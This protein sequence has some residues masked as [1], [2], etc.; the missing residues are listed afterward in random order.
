MEYAPGTDFEVGTDMILLSDLSQL[1]A[2][3]ALPVSR[4]HEEIKPNSGRPSENSV[5]VKYWIRGGFVPLGA[6]RQDGSSHPHAGTGFGF[7]WAISWPLYA[8]Y[9]V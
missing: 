8:D 6:K 5:M 3:N 4:N 2:A 7:C 1:S 9:L